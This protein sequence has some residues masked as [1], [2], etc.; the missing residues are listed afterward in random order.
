MNKFT[1]HDINM[2]VKRIMLEYNLQDKTEPFVQI[3]PRIYLKGHKD[4]FFTDPKV[5]FNMPL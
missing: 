1:L 5:K 4:N 2:E 3:R